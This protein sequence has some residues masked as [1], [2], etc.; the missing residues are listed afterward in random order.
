MTF[1]ILPLAPQAQ[2]PSYGQTS[3]LSDSDDDMDIDEGGSPFKGLRFSR[4]AGAIITP[5]ET[6]TE[7]PQWMR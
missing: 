6:V 1:T 2:A 5:G 7:D 4:S 3:P